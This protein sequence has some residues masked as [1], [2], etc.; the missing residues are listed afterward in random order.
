M[1]EDYYQAAINFYK[2]NRPWAELFHEAG[3]PVPDEFRALIEWMMG[4]RLVG[5]VKRLD[6]NADL[7]EIIRGAK[8]IIEEARSAGFSIR[9]EPVIRFLSARLN[10]RF[11]R[12]LHGSDLGLVE[13]IEK[14]IH[15]AKDLKIALHDRIAQELFFIFAQKTLREWIENYQGDA[16]GQPRLR[17]IQAVLHL[18]AQLGFNMDRYEQ[19]LK[20]KAEVR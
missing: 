5:C 1:R 2:Q 19:Q 3:R 14:V 16:S 12:L 7:E 6:S 15:L 17:T 10:A 11:E 4:E 20:A 8:S 9:T 13:N 18:G